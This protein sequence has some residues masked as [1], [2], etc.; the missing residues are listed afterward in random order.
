MDNLRAMKIERERER[1][2]WTFCW[3]TFCF[4]LISSNPS[5]YFCFWRSSSFNLSSSSSFNCPRL[6]V[7]SN[8]RS[9]NVWTNNKIAFAQVSRI[10]F[11][12]AKL[13]HFASDPIVSRTIRLCMSSGRGRLNAWGRYG[14]MRVGSRGLSSTLILILIL[15]RIRI[16]I[17]RSFLKVG[18]ASARMNDCGWSHWKKTQVWILTRSF[19]T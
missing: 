16:R 18:G 8:K 6:S 13:A 14:M 1:E 3:S 9:G 7:Y 10:Q 4:K 17:R 5:S 12:I 15:I 2:C 11:C 19:T